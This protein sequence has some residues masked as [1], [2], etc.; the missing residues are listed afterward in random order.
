MKRLLVGITGGMGCGQS[1]AAELLHA[2]SQAPLVS[3]DEAGRQAA[4]DVEVKNNLRQAFGDAFFSADGRLDRKALGS[5]IF[6]DEIKRQLL[7]RIIHPVMLRIVRREL[8]KADRLEGSFCYV[9]LDGALIYELDMAAELDLVVVVTAPESSRIARLVARDRF[10]KEEIRTRMASQWPLPEKVHRA[11][12]HI[13][14]SGSKE[15]LSHQIDILHEW[16]VKKC[17]ERS[18]GLH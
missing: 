1:L 2:R 5:L 7:N 8:A 4:D 16:L 14:N 9:L 3:M 15:E 12:Y 10:S 11:D 6:A 18:S 17:E 13:D